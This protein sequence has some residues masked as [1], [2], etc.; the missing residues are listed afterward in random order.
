MFAGEQGDAFGQT[1]VRLCIDLLHQRNRQIHVDAECRAFWL[2]SIACS[3]NPAAASGWFCASIRSAPSCAPSC[4]TSATRALSSAAR[5]APFDEPAIAASSSLRISASASSGVSTRTV[6][7]R[8]C[9]AVIVGDRQPSS[10]A[11]QSIPVGV[12]VARRAIECIREHRERG[13]VLDDTVSPVHLRRL[14]IGLA[15]IGERRGDRQRCPDER[16]RHVDADA[17]SRAVLHLEAGDRG[18]DVANR[19]G[20]RGVELV[21][22]DE[23][24]A[25][26]DT[27]GGRPV[28][29]GGV[30]VNRRAG[31]FEAAVVVA[32]PADVEGRVVMSRSPRESPHRS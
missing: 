29:S 26:R 11:A 24:G 18:R 21:A 2:Q 14:V 5:T 31:R 17:R 30:E 15:G 13:L 12:P 16:E 20:R 9:A 28:N 27:E 4:P 19:D 23:V 10:T 3:T 8:V 22:A 1:A 7:A 25:R 32:V 6:T